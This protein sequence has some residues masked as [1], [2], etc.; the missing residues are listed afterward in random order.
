MTQQRSRKAWLPHEQQIFETGLAANLT[1]AEISASL[2]GRTL[3]A[4]RHH[5]A[6]MSLRAYPSTSTMMDTPTFKPD[7]SH[8]S[9]TT[10]DMAKPPRDPDLSSAAKSHDHEAIRAGNTQD[11]TLPLATATPILTVVVIVKQ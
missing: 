11:G 7:P 8:N 9:G 10:H 2:P 3:G 1:W 6:N 5:L 4:C